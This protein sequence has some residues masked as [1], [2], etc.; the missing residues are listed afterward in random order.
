[1]NANPWT[2]R[3]AGPGTIFFDIRASLSGMDWSTAF[4][5]AA[6]AKKLRSEALTEK[7]GTLKRKIE[8]VV[9]VIKVLGYT[10]STRRITKGAQYC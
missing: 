6:K 4:L 8:S 1:M 7:S 10:L 3:P 5:G 9:M 2:S